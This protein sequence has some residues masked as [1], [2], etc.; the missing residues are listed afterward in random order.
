MATMQA[1]FIVFAGFILLQS[2]SAVGATLH[3]RILHHPLFPADS[4]APSQPPNS[5]QRPHNL[6]SS[7][8]TD[9]HSPPSPSAHPLS[10]TTGGAAAP[11][12]A[13]T[14]ETP[15]NP[16]FPTY[17]SLSPP[18]PPPAVSSSTAGE[19]SSIPTFPA[20]ISSLV[21][22]HSHSSSS[23]HSGKSPKLIAATVVLCLVAVSLFASFFL[24]RRHRNRRDSRSL[25]HD[26]K[27]P[28]PPLPEQIPHSDNAV[29][30]PPYSSTSDGRPPKLPVRAG[31]SANSSEFL[32][33]GTLA[34]SNS[35]E[36]EPSHYD[37]QIESPEI[38]PLP[39][40]RP[41]HKHN[42]V[43]NS[44]SDATD[45][46]EFYSPANSS[47]RI[48]NFRSASTTRRVSEA[49]ARIEGFQNQANNS[50]FA[51]YP[52]SSSSSPENS[53]RSVPSVLVNSASDSSNSCSPEYIMRPPPLIHRVPPPPPPPPPPTKGRAAFMEPPVLPQPSRSVMGFKSGE[54]QQNSHALAWNR[55]GN[56]RNDEI[57]KPK[58]KGLHWDKV[59][60]SSDRVTVWDQLEAGSFLL[61]E[62]MMETL[63]TA[64][65]TVNVAANDLTPR[66]SMMPMMNQEYR[67]LDPK[68][69]QNIAILLRALN[70]TVE[71]VCDSL[72]EGNADMLGAELLE[73]LLKMTPTKEEE[74]M[75]RE[76]KDESPQKLGPAEKFLKAVLDIPFA[77]KRVD[78]LLYITNFESEVEYLKRSFEALEAACDELRNSR[79]F[80]KLLEAVL[81]TGNRMNIGTNRGDAHA[82]KLDTLLKLVDVKGTDG[83]TTLL[84]FVVQE[85]I[86]AQGTSTQT[87][88]SSLQDD[89][90]T[91]KRGLQ[92]VSGLCGELINVKK[93]A[94]MDSYVLTNDVQK[95]IKGINKV[96]DIA[97]LNEETKF[98]DSMRLFLKK[99]SGEIG[100]IQAL[101][102]ESL[103]KV[104]ELTEY[105]HGNL[106]KEEAHPLRIFMVVRDFLSVLD[107]VCKE[108]AKVNERTVISS[109][110]NHV[111][112]VNPSLPHLFPD[113]SNGGRL[114][115]EGESLL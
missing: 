15:E 52:D 8:A 24:I 74:R 101:E 91:K 12:A 7:N 55:D 61:N 10:S 5:S 72:M 1:I 14:T 53:V 11:S 27:E 86:K 30:Y 45:D 58:L 82:F 40:L 80:L 108:V 31:V 56:E 93:A 77:F 44:N 25:R 71:E 57:R 4:P 41:L 66:R 35:A 97:R 62:E 94:A 107:K 38:R 85:I 37:N 51:S 113:Q 65:T 13:I 68:K 63:F 16:F 76:Y 54:Q 111:M 106:A 23:S 46:D 99:A 64:N 98:V 73:S 102:I 69:S 75:L 84:H 28:P 104:K 87:A 100:M 103:L 115:D 88:S 50:K 42:H 70:V 33:L 43:R 22:P 81:K 47:G 26:F 79:M 9:H 21:V 32:Y 18:P 95:L 112:P 96:E 59:R 29:L 48:E 110:R 34:A 114:D 19:G 89:M 90:E 78:A 2:T 83:K 67:V 20:N 105:F 49:L 39:P 60:A 109:N 36:F 92:V 3:R 6:T 17:P